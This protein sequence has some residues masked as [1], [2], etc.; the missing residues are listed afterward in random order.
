MSLFIEQSS[1]PEGSTWDK[2]KTPIEVTEEFLETAANAAHIQERNY[3]RIKGI[4]MHALRLSDGRVWDV[5]NGF[6]TKEFNW[7]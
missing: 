2:R 6:R 4:N 7:K 1:Y 3:I 5:V